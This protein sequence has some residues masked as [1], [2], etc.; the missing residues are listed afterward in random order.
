MAAVCTPEALLAHA[1]AIAHTAARGGWIDERSGARIGLDQRQR[2]RWTR[3]AAMLR[4]HALEGM[5]DPVAGRGRSRAS[6]R[7]RA[8]SDRCR[9]GNVTNNNSN[10]SHSRILLGRRRGA[11]RA[12]A[13]RPKEPER[14]D[15]L[16]RPWG[17]IDT[18]DTLAAGSPRKQPRRR[19]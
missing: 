10:Q 2:E 4:Q 11:R 7:G 15:P 12:P 5:A 6:E 19:R 3:D 1:D 17:R 16:Y 13:D 14:N 8:T 9:H 18:V